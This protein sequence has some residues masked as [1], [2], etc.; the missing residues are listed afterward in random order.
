MRSGRWQQ[1]RISAPDIDDRVLAPAGQLQIGEGQA[2]HA[3]LRD[4]HA[5]VVQIDAISQDPHGR[6]L[7]EQILRPLRCRGIVGSHEKHIVGAQQHFRTRHAGVVLPAHGGDNEPR[8][9]L[10]YKLAHRAAGNGGVV[11]R[12]LAVLKPSQYRR[13]QFRPKQDLGKVHTDNGTDDPER[14]GDAV[15][16]GRLGA[17]RGID[18]GLQ[19]GGARHRSREHAHEISQGEIDDQR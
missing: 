7:A 11:D 15:A 17:A 9:Q 5:Q 12:D 8:R 2:H 1:S 4:E 3:A 10:G 13:L 14:V 16:D 19:R 18:R 6:R